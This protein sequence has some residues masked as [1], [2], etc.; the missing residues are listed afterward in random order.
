MTNPNFYQRDIDEVLTNAL[1]RGVLCEERD[2]YNFIAN[3]E[4]AHSLGPR[5]FFKHHSSGL[6]LTTL[7]RGE[8]IKV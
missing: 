1:E 5:D 8:E 3:W 2:A 4:Y 7:F 6:E